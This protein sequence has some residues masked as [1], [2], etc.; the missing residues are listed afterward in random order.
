MADRIPAENPTEAEQK[1]LTAAADGTLA[2]LQPGEIGIDDLDGGAGWDISR[3]IRAS[4]LADLLTGTQCPCP[5]GKSPRMVRLRGAR[6]TGALNLEAATLTCPLLLEA[7][8]IDEPVVLTGATAHTIQ[9]V[10][11]RLPGLI[12]DQLRTTGDLWLWKTVF[13]ANS[14]VR[15]LGARVAG[16]L[17]M[18]GTHLTNPGGLALVA[19]GLSVEQDMLCGEGFAAEGEIRLPG[20]GIGGALDMNGACL[21][22][23]G[24]TALLGNWLTVGRSATCGNGFTAAGMISLGAARI[25]SE[26]YMSGAHLANPGGIALKANRLTVGDDM[27]CKDGFSAEGEINLSGAHVSGELS[28]TGAHLA[29]PGGAALDGENLTVQGLM[30]CGGGFRAE[31]EIRLPGA[32]ISGQLDMSGAHLANPEGRVL[33]A[34]ELTVDRG[35]F[36]SEGFTAEGEMRMIAARIGGRLAMTGARLANP[37]GWALNLEAAEMA[38]LILRP[39]QPPAGHV[40]LADAKAGK[41]YDDPARWPASFDLEG[42]EY[43]AFGNG[44]VSSRL[45]LKWLARNAGGYVPQLYDQLADVYRRAGDEQAARRVAVAKQW[46]RRRWFNPLNWLWYATVGYGYR[47]WLTGIWLAALVGLG[48]WVFSGAYPAHMKAI[49]IN[50]PPFHAPVYALDIL[51]PVIGLGQKTAWQPQGSAYLYWSWAMTVAGW[52]LATAVVAGLTGILKRD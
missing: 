46:H 23:P 10:S 19:D 16:R 34:D 28:M 27:T 47:T 43:G 11:C 18:S 45:R 5:G 30:A 2:D 14:E 7:C 20:A 38:T 32:H 9:M 17:I 4:L 52:I 51:L 39:R 21:T 48:T 1:L 50:P 44:D 13:T 49:S 24:G 31:G 15:L 25:G 41:F 26:L 8:Y 6:I 12:A 35:M 22:N 33:Y 36:C 40:C 42:F 3:Q 29:N 37:D